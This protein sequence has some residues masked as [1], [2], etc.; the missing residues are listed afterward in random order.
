MSLR[1]A[2][3]ECGGDVPWFSSWT[4]PGCTEPDSIA[5]QVIKGSIFEPWVEDAKQGVGNAVKTMITFWIA[6]PDPNVGDVNGAVAE[7]ISFVQSKLVW[8]GAVIMCFVVAFQCARMMWEQN[9]QPLKK[10]ALMFLTYL[11]VG[12]LAV[13]AVALGLMITSALA[14]TIL[15]AATVG[16]SFSDNLFSLFNTDIGITSGIL[17]I[18]L[19]IIAMLIGCF[20]CILMIGRGGATFIILAVLQTQA[21]ATATEGGEQGVKTSIGWLEGLILYK[22]VAAVIYGVGFKFLSSDLG[23]PDNG[24]LQILFGLTILLMA[25]FSLPATMR[26]TA[27]AVA[28]VSQ[29]SGVGNTVGSAAPAL[30][31]AGVR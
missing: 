27:P 16:P 31:A 5:T 24:L 14:A 10:I 1:L 9:G 4:T 26:V 20:Q 22:L 17:L 25:V 8:L 30:V 6:V 7:V 3:Q 21:A 2:P 19:L 13:P 12:A 15:E 29:G 28:P 18:F 11:T 23:Q